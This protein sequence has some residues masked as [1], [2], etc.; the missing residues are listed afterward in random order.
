M[1][2]SP[3][4]FG[5]GKSIMMTGTVMVKEC[6]SMFEKNHLTITREGMFPDNRKKF[7]QCALHSSLQKRGF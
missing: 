1:E 2:M 3:Q 6:K 4:G 5:K 7:E